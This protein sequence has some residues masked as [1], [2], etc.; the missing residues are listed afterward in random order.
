MLLFY[1]IQL[2]IE[3]R[4]PA[5]HVRQG[6]AAFAYIYTYATLLTVLFTETLPKDVATKSL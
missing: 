2:W 6:W 5:A 4:D 1:H 3:I